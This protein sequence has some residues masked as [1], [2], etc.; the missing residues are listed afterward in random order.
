MDSLCSQMC[1]DRSNVCFLQICP[2]NFVPTPDSRSC[3]KHFKVDCYPVTD[4]VQASLVCSVPRSHLLPTSLPP[5]QHP[6]SSNQRPSLVNSVNKHPAPDIQHP[7]FLPR[8]VYNHIVTCHKHI[9]SCILTSQC[10]QQLYPDLTM[11]TTVVS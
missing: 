8:V 3:S 2:A 1:L 9:I 4:T 7:H 10:Q 6:S 5:V 11:P